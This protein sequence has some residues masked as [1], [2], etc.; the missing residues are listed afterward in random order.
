MISVESRC[1]LTYTYILYARVCVQRNRACCRSTR[2]YYYYHRIYSRGDRRLANKVVRVLR[3][4]VVD[5]PGNPPPFPPSRPAETYSPPTRP[6]ILIPDV[7]LILI[8][9]RRR[10]VINYNCAPTLYITRN[11]RALVYTFGNNACVNIRESRRA[12]IYLT[13]A[14]VHKYIYI[15]V[16]TACTQVVNACPSS[17]GRGVYV[18]KPYARIRRARRAR[19]RSFVYFTRV[20]GRD[21]RVS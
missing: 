7:V 9:R 20:Y 8:I 21:A 12:D 2:T 13:C 4:A 11:T 16:Y 5:P 14:R 19:T 17:R 1:N 15:Y 18:V 10:R 3:A 6:A